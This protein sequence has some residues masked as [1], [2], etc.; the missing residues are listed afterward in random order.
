MHA[1]RRK[2]GAEVWSAVRSGRDLGR[3]RAR[4]L[5][6]ADLAH[7]HE[8][9]L[10]HWTAHNGA[11]HAAWTSSLDHIRSTP[12]Y[13]EGSWPRSTGGPRGEPRRPSAPR[14]GLHAGTGF[15]FTVL[16]PGDDDVIGRVYLYP[17][18]AEDWTSPCTPGCGPTDR[19]ST[20]RSPTPSQPGSPPTGPGNGWTAAA[21]ESCRLRLSPAAALAAGMP[22]TPLSQT[23]AD[24]RAWDRPRPGEPP[25][26]NGLSDE[27]AAVAPSQG[28]RRT[29][30]GAGHGSATIEI[31]LVDK[32]FWGGWVSVVASSVGVYVQ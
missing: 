20:Y 9:R 29:D 22:R 10:D 26:P 3:V 25:L 2:S 1:A 31:S 28:S 7:G 21:A 27:E 11:D 5:R 14:R 30:E 23:V 6:A 15:T 19:A 24:T 17:S 4:R 8:F 16:D 32:G 12:G 13:A 18:R